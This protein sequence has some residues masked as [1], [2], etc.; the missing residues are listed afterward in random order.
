METLA[1]PDARLTLSVPELM[2]SKKSRR[3]DKTVTLMLE[4][5]ESL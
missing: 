4:I 2:D 5:N 3:T 1:M